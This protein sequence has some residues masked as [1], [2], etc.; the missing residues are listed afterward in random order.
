VD[1]YNGFGELDED[2]ALH[3]PPAAPAELLY[4]NE[5]T[6]RDKL[7]RIV[8]KI[9]TI[10]GVTNTWNYAYD[11]AGRL[12]TVTRTPQGGT[13]IPVADH[14]YD[15]NGNRLCTNEA[16]GTGCPSPAVYDEQD[17]LA[18]D[19]AGRTYSYSTAGELETVTDG[20]DVTTYG[21]DP[22]GN[23]RTV[24]L[25]DTTAIEY[26]ID[27][28]GR[29]IGKR[30]DT[31]LQQGFL[32]S[33]GLRIVAELDGTGAVLARFVYGTRPNVPD[34][35]VKDGSTYRILTDHLGSV[36]LVVDASTG[37]I[38]QR[39]DY[40]SWG[41]PTFTGPADFQPFG[42][43]GGLYDPDTGLVRFGARDYDARTGRWTSK[44]PIRFD[45]SGSNLYEYS[46]GDPVNG[47]DPTGLISLSPAL[48]GFL[49]T[50]LPNTSVGVSVSG[51]AGLGGEI[52]ISLDPCGNIGWSVTGGLGFGFGVSAGPTFTAGSG[53]GAGSNVTGSISGGT[54]VVGGS[55]SKTL[56]VFG[57]STSLS[58]GWGFGLGA[59]FGVP[60]QGSLSLPVGG[61][62][63]CGCAQ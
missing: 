48:A 11:V 61:I 52:G 44:D 41:N 7:G 38:A 26:L 50:I 8:Q 20:A 29:R 10:Q 57:S 56:G 12:D 63:G 32:W 62:P 31:V 25:P 36:R 35:M 54:G 42:F 28:L 2:S 45:A 37:A 53:S 5:Y 6:Q 21:Y 34:Y 59:S 58:G 13:P 46:L 16:P 49:G 22:L 3:E 19:G 60:A 23:L 14:A 18:S 30:V 40:D 39:I 15:L 1:L 4:R 17:R 27:P 43:A 9:E 24:T 55:V 47:I 51:G 33:D